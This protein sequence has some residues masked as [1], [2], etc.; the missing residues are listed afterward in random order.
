MSRSS[1]GRLV[2]LEISTSGTTIS[3]SGQRRKRED[4]LI[5]RHS[6][7]KRSKSNDSQI[8]VVKVHKGK[9]EYMSCIGD[10]QSIE[11][12]DADS[13]IGKESEPCGNRIHCCLVVSPARR[14]LHAY[15]V[16]GELLDTLR[17]AIQGHKSLFKDGKILHRDISENNIIIAENVS[18][19]GPKGMLIYL[20]LAKELETLPSGASH[21]TGTMQF[22]AIEVLQCKGHTYRHNLESFFYFFTWMCIRYGHETV[23][24]GEEIR[25]PQ[26]PQ[27]KKRRPIMTSRLRRWYSGTYT[28]IGQNKL[29]ERDKNG[30]EG[31]VA[32]YSP[33]FENM[34]R[35]ARELRQVL[36]PIRDDLHRHIPRP[37]S[38]IA[39]TRLGK[40]IQV[41]V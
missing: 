5:D 7:M 9:G 15:K 1:T 8:E 20:D 37:A 34:K 24:D 32:E 4:E 16:V 19:G 14:S 39:L 35:L 18:R 11:E 21:R 28:E 26:E 23:G 3:S 12:A 22:I 27:V 10:V 36:F 41:I 31:I 25:V 13:L 30:F 6:A 38:N 2:G 40:D 29:G 33:R 17:D